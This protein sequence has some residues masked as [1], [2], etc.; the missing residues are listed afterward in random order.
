[1]RYFIAAA[2]FAIS[3]GASAQAIK[4]E[5][6]TQKFS[7][8]EVA[9][10]EM[11]DLSFK[12]TPEDIDAYSKYFYFHRDNTSFDDA[13]ADVK[14][15]DALAAGIRFHAGRTDVAYPYAGT[16]G[17]VIGGAIGNAL[18]DAIF[19]AA[20]RRRIRRINLRNCMAFKDYQR[21]GMAKERWQAFN[22]EEGNGTVQGEKRESYLLKQALVASGPMPKQKMLEP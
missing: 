15:C 5:P 18:A 7:V 6:P 16:I 20:E 12:E 4:P 3:S 2:A 22:F 10:I 19:G 8:E 9:K 21:Y 1:M 14:E 11:P 17:G 13:Y